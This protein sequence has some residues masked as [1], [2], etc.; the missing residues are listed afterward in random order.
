MLSNTLTVL[1]LLAFSSAWTTDGFRVLGVALR[2]AHGKLLRPTL[3]SESANGA[4]PEPSQSGQEK[5]VPEGYLS[6]DFASIGDGK[7]MRVGLYI[8]LALVPVLFLVPFF[9]SRDFVP[10]M[11]PGAMIP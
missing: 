1:L 9:L 4:G 3:R 7:Q 2:P 8:G 10:P 6:S 5:S 11:D